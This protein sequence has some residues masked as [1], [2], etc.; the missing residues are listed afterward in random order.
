MKPQV[1]VILTVYKRTEFLRQALDSAMAQTFSAREIIVAD[2]SGNGAARPI[3]RPL[4]DAGQLRYLA[5]ERT[6]GVAGSIRKALAETHGEFISILNDDDVWEADFLSRLMVPLQSNSE[7][8]LAF[9]DHWV[10]SEN[11]SIDQEA[12]DENTKRYGRLHL[13]EGDMSDPAHLVLVANAV[14][15]AMAALFRKSALDPALLTDEVSAAY[16]F[17]ISCLLAASNGKFYYVPDRLT[18]Y[19][20]HQRMETAR[21]DP[22]KSQNHVYIFSQLLERNWFPAMKGHLRLKLAEALFQLGR[23]RLRFN[24]SRE[25]RQYFLESFKMQ[26]GL[27]SAVAAAVSLVPKSL[28]MLSGLSHRSE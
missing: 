2:D 27:R 19:R 25:A 21:H 16:D 4:A 24:R 22:A 5:N 11:G 12:T 14:P 8:V 7:R 6:L 26:P 20:M 13:K 9:S 18:R 17:W 15:L 28:R 1:S 3:C 10:I 23:D